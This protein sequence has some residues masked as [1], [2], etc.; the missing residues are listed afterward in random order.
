[1][2][3]SHPVEVVKGVGEQ[4]LKKLNKLGIYTVED[5]LYHFPRSYEDRSK[6]IK[7]SQI[8]YNKTNTIL[9]KI[10]TLPQNIKRGKKIITKVNLR[11]DSGSIFAVWFGQPYLKKQFKLNDTYIFTGKVTYKYGQIQIESPD[12]EK[13]VDDKDIF[14]KR[15]IPIYPSTYKLS[16]KVIRQIIYNA[17]V[18]TQNQLIEF[19]PLW[20]RKKYKLADYNYAIHNIHFP[21]SEDSFL[22]SR[23]RLV[24]EELFLLQTGLMSIKNK[25]GKNKKAIKFKEI[26]EL[27]D[28]IKSLPF[29]LTNAQKRVFNEIKQDMINDKI[30]NRLVQGDVGSGKTII[31]AL[32]LFLAVKNGYQGVMMAPTEVLATQHYKGLT[33]LLEK[34]NIKTGLLTGS[35]TK[36]QKE[37]ILNQIKNGDIDIVF[38]T[39]ALIQEKVSFKSLGL[40]ITDEQHRFGV[41]QRNML[42]EKGNNPDVLVMTATP[43][44]RT[45]A[46]ILYGDLDISIIDE[47]PPGRKNI[48]TYAVNSSYRHRIYQF[49]KKELINGRQAYVICPMVE[50]AE[51]ENLK[52]V[53]S[54]TEELQKEFKGY[55]VSYLHGKMKPKE[56]QKIMN[57][58]SEGKIQ[59]LV[60]TTVIEVGVNVPNATIMLIENAERFGLAQLHQLRGR[61]GR[62]EFKSYCI[63]I[64]DSK[65]KVTIER[66]KIMKKTNNGFKISETDLKIRGPGEFFGTRQHGLPDLK[67]A[68]LYKDIPILKKAQEA[69]EIILSIDPNL[70]KEEHKFLK[71]KINKFFEEKI[72]NISL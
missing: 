17:L 70:D 67:I 50:E 51:E 8:E 12:Y 54:Y 40:V 68:N 2:D 47:L 20:I 19:L 37:N 30:M 3:L 65:N 38:G 41:R 61:V 24:F 34:F 59:I 10:N 62:G 71:E 64:T 23:K 27:D 33:P 5:L 32:A 22:I 46:L 18:E 28:F 7:I 9:A 29:E 43:I 4:T 36:K 21:E 66:M 15:I 35:L 58:F 39:H 6:I 63:L 45:L 56:K 60:S 42:S 26:K 44:P 53:I 14:T 31:A 16:Q 52:S 57:D 11:D 69:S 25:I 13:I 48:D 55:K 72:K 1:M 49:I